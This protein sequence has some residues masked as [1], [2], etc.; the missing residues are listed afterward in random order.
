[1]EQNNI[2][3]E[4]GLNEVIKKLTGQDEKIA[5]D[6]ENILMLFGNKLFEM[7]TEDSIKQAKTRCK[8]EN[9]V[10]VEQSDVELVCTSLFSTSSKKEDILKEKEV[11]NEEYQ[12][13]LDLLEKFKSSKENE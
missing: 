9:D 7:I 8:G 10:T 6:A 2:F 11:V 5:K 4:E 3:D 1:M 12:K 13:K